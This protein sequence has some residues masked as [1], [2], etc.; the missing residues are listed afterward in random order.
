LLA[1]AFNPGTKVALA[2][3]P[4]FHVSLRSV[5][6]VASDRV[7]IDRR[8][9]YVFPPGPDP[10]YRRGYADAIR[11]RARRVVRP[12]QLG[13]TDCRAPPI[14]SARGLSLGALLPGHASLARG[15]S[16]SRRPGS[17]AVWPACASPKKEVANPDRSPSQR[18]LRRRSRRPA[19]SLRIRSGWPVRDGASGTSST[20]ICASS[21]RCTPE[22]ELNGWPDG[23]GCRPVR[24]LCG[25][26]RRLAVWKSPRRG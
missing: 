21:R 14:C 12:S 7:F 2:P 10:L 26:A 15:S 6:V 25:G 17:L 20:G 8:Q 3:P 16:I 18:G 1:G 24:A 13:V 23:R 19:R 5:P 22:P 9:G 11:G 4:V